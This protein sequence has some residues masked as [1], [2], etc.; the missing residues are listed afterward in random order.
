MAKDNALSTYT[1]QGKNA[2]GDTIKGET[3]ATSVQEA[4]NLLRRRGIS[5]TK[6]RKLSICF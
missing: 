1:W 2:K 3:S 6:V 4:R 5:A